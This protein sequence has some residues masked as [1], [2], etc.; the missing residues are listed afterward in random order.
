GVSCTFS[1]KTSGTNQ[2]VGFV[3][4][5]GGVT[6]DKTVVQ[7]LVGTGTDEGAG[8]V[9]GLFDLATGE[10]VEL[11]VTN[12][13]SSNTVTIQHGNLTVVAIT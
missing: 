1:A 11:W 6:A 5:E 12:N 4:A 3:I 7:R 2:L 9:H 13:T 10:Y 8:A